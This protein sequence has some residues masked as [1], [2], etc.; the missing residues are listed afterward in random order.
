MKIY[1]FVLVIC[2]LVIHNLYANEG[3]M[4][5][6]KFDNE[7]RSYIAQDDIEQEVD[8]EAMSVEV[9][10]AENFQHEEDYPLNDLLKIKNDKEVMISSFNQRDV[11]R[12]NDKF[13]NIDKKRKII[14]TFIDNLHSFLNNQYMHCEPKYIADLITDLQKADIEISQSE[15]LDVFKMMRVENAIDDVLYNI[16]ENLIVD[17]FALNDLDLKA[18]LVKNI[19]KNY[20]KKSKNY[21]LEGLFV[22]FKKY[23][24]EVDSCSYIEYFK[25][26]DAVGLPSDSLSSKN[27]QVKD[28]AVAAYTRNII[29][30]ETYNKIKYIK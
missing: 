8:T 29:S 2:L 18:K 14:N 20:D 3:N 17:Y 9:I 22:G 26:R 13:R 4:V 24:D 5:E 10:P 27:N 21:N 25:L 12:I 19:F 1:F 16:L 30:L 11:L 23:P 6:L 15:L 7:L 28:L